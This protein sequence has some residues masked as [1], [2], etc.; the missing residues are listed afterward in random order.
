[1]AIDIELLCLRCSASLPIN[2]VSNSFGLVD[3]K[4]DK[5]LLQE[6]FE[7]ADDDASGILD[8]AEKPSRHVKPEAPHPLRAALETAPAFNPRE[9]QRLID[10]ELLQWSSLSEGEDETDEG[11]LDMYNDETLVEDGLM[12]YSPLKAAGIRM[13]PPLSVPIP[14]R[15]PRQARSAPSPPDE[16]PATIRLLC[17]FSVRPKSW[18]TVSKACT[19]INQRHDHNRPG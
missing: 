4:K 12:L 8:A 19:K 15:E 17:G 1:M 6:H 18:E 10:D 13:E 14:R 9:G 2:H 16:P 7:D 11:Q 3:R 5:R